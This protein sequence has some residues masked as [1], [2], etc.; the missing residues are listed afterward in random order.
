MMVH[1]IE[2]LYEQNRVQQRQQDERVEKQIEE[3]SAEERADDRVRRENVAERIAPH[4][5]DEVQISDEAREVIRSQ[6]VGPVPEGSVVPAETPQQLSDTW[7]AFGYQEAMD[8]F[9]GEMST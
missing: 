3:R 2:R 9:D 8:H 4:L 6:H 1:R 7:Y 5:H